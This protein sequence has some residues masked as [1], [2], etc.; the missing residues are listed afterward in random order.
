MNKKY[1]LL[2]LF[3]FL[4]AAAAQTQSSSE[5][6][7][8]LGAGNHSLRYTVE[9]GSVNSGFGGSLGVGYTRFFSNSLGV[10][11]GLEANLFGSSIALNDYS[12]NSL[13]QTPP[14]LTDNFYLRANYAGIKETQRFVFVQIP[15]ML[16]FQKATGKK[17][18]F[19][20]ATGVKAGFPVSAR[21]NQTVGTLTTTGYSDYTNQTYQNMPNRGFETQNDIESSGSLKLG[22]PVMLAVEGGMKWR[23]SSATY[24]Y[25]AVY[26]DY[27]LTDI[28]KSDAG[29]LLEY[30]PESP[31][32]YTRNS[33]LQI[34]LLNASQ[35]IKPFAVGIKIRMAFGSGKMQK[36]KSVP[37][38]LLGLL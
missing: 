27:G 28:N 24:I 2:I 38:P 10:S 16:Q 25:T 30:N 1:I 11:L 4:F 5:F 34:N 21:W 36:K 18:F 37:M 19:F 8:S 12:V 17:A 22:S 3:S 35:G 33:I 6:G 14:G 26:F 32:D 29:D 20:L 31:I 7:I 9:N 13:I 23:I 15:L